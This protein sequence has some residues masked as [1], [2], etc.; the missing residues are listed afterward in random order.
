[1]ESGQHSHLRFKRQRALHHLRV[2]D[3]TAFM[4]LQS[5][6]PADAER[7]DDLTRRTREMSSELFHRAKE[8]AARNEEIE[9]A[10]KLKSEF[11]RHEP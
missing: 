1:M 5:S 9:R 7:A 8:L 4:K 3:V 10:N 6:A 11:D 2:E